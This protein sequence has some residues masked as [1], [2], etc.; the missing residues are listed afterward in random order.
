MEPQISKPIGQ[1]HS[2]ASLLTS[3][4]LLAAILAPVAGLV[5]WYGHSHSGSTG[6]VAAGIAGLVCWVAASLA[7][8]LAFFGQRLGFGLES[9]LGGIALRTGL[10]LAVGVLL[11][12]QAGPL[13]EAGVFVM[14]LIL[15]LCSLLA[16][17]LLALRFIPASRG[18]MGGTTSQADAW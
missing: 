16:E 5:A 1:S 11:H 10:P 13:A 6:L 4:A 2:V 15:Y 18:R 9:L 14:I 8:T 12:K 17:T 3:C 7:L